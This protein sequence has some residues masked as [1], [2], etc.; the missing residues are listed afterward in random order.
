MILCSCSS[1]LFTIPIISLWW[2]RLWMKSWTIYLF[3]IF[4]TMK[5]RKTKGMKGTKGFF[6]GKKWDPSTHIMRKKN[7]KSCLTLYIKKVF[8]LCT[9]GCRRPRWWNT[10]LLVTKRLIKTKCHTIWIAIKLNF[11]WNVASLSKQRENKQCT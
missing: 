7:L 11:D 6:W 10:R 8:N 4:A 5:E 1:K 3:R 2:M 9:Y